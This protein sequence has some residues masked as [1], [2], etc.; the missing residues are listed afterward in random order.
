MNSPQPPPGPRFSSPAAPG[1][2]PE[3]F[4]RKSGFRD[5]LIYTL[6]AV[7]LLGAGAAAVYFYSLPEQEQKAIQERLDKTRL[8]LGAKP[9]NDPETTANKLAETKT[10]KIVDAIIGS[11]APKDPPESA[12][13]KPAPAVAP[14]GGSSAYATGFSLRLLPPSDPKAPKASAEFTRY[15]Q[16]LRLS[17]VLQGEPGRA[18]LNGKTYRPGET[19]DFDLG[20]TLAKIDPRQKELLLRDRSGA[21]IRLAY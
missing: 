16:T 5:Y 11:D 12:A 7:L 14:A 18:V 13:T 10:S 4:Q 2:R 8:K 9:T 20:V 17:A 3:K 6:L 15:V 1:Y 19:L 21:E